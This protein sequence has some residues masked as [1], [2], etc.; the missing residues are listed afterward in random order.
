M[1]PEIAPSLQNVDIETKAADLA[2][3]DSEEV[4]I[5]TICKND[6]C[7][8]AYEGPQTNETTCV[9]HSGI[10]IFH[11]GLKY[12]S[13]CQ[14][15][16]TDFETF[17]GQVGCQKGNHIWRK[18]VSLFNNILKFSS[19]L[20]SLLKILVEPSHSSIV[21]RDREKPM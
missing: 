15:K 9:Y 8:A 2:T 18:D 17:I 7:S 13:C 5:G 19:I 14:R 16:T 6:G 3:S 4:K 11:E 20:V 1:K 10:P 21:L 12:W